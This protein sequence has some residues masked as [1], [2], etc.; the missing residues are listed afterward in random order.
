MGDASPR[1][2]VLIAVGFGDRRKDL[3]SSVGG[4]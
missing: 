2:Q 4:P 3:I 1:M